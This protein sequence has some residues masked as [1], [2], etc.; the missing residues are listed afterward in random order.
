MKNRKAQ[1]VGFINVT[2]ILLTSVI[3]SIR[4]IIHCHSKID[5][6]F[7]LVIALSLY[8]L[9]R[10]FCSEKSKDQQHRVPNFEPPAASAFTHISS[11][12]EADR[13]QTKEDRH[14]R[15]CHHRRIS[16]VTPIIARTFSLLRAF[17]RSTRRKPK[18]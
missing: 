18:R 17:S 12:R 7:I 1:N 10:S 6:I 11:I 3:N 2:E 16:I 9:R 8:A 14:C 13:H 5:K 4:L 15:R